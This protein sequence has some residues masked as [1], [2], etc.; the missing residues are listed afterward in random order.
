MARYHPC[1]V[2]Q[3]CLEENL[4]IEVSFE[5]HHA[6]TN[7]AQRNKN[8]AAVGNYIITEVCYAD[9]IA[10]FMPDVISLQRA[11]D[12]LDQLMSAY[13]MTICSLKTKTMVMSPTLDEKDYTGSIVSLG[14]TPLEN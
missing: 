2:S 12:I 1:P 7:R 5:I 6:A 9:D 14:N 10:L 13:G 11:K 3:K 4:G 8:L